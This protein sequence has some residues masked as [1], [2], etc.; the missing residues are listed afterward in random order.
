[1][2]MKA[3]YLSI[4]IVFSFLCLM[5]CEQ[6]P[7]QQTPLA[8]DEM[9]LSKQDTLQVMNLVTDFMN[10]LKDKRYADAV[11]MLHKVNPTSP[12]SQPELLDNKEI[13]KTMAEL[14]HFPIRNYEIKEYTFK[15]AYDNEVKC[16]IETEPASSDEK[17]QTLKF[18]LKPVRYFGNWSLCLKN[19]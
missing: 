2:D 9:A 16:V 6:K 4:L 5:S 14:K 11:V 10:A 7:K 12:Y 18:R 17:S 15:I 19:Y 1:M 3:K 13:E 8:D